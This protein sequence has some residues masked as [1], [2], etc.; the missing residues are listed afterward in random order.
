MTSPVGVVAP[1][2]GDELVVGATKAT[3][4][5]SGTDVVFV[6]PRAAGA[7]RVA[8]LTVDSPCSTGEVEADDEA[9]SGDVLAAG[10]SVSAL[11]SSTRSRGV[12]AV[13]GAELISDEVGDGELGE[14]GSG[15]V[16]RS[17]T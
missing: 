15:E 3:V 17:S 12:L 13:V 6:N 9:P 7:C 14:T 5:R 8:A 1:A 11:G 4:R 16:L 2:C 10:R